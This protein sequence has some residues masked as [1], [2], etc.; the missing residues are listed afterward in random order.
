MEARPARGGDRLQVSWADRGSQSAASPTSAGAASV[1]DRSA[2]WRK[3]AVFSFPT[4]ESNVALLT[5]DH[6]QHWML[7]KLCLS[8]VSLCVSSRNSWWC[9][10]DVQ[11]G[12]CHGWVGFHLQVYLECD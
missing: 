3:A 7:T 8:M 11:I 12:G 10:F 6:C 9:F 5:R 4:R 1:T 2:G